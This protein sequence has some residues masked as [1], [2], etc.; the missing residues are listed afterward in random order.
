M[1]QLEQPGYSST[2]PYGH[3]LIPALAFP[4]PVFGIE[5]EIYE[6]FLIHV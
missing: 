4:P 6:L 5:V 3:S 1:F 2:D